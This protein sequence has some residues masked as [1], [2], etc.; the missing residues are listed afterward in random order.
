MPVVTG[1]GFLLEN[2]RFVTTRYVLEKW[3]FYESSKNQDEYK[4][5]EALNLMASNG[6]DVIAYFTAVSSTGKRFSFNSKSFICNRSFDKIESTELSRGVRM[7]V[8]KAVHG[9]SDWAYYQTNEK[10][11]LKY[12]ALSSNLPLGTELE[13][14][15]FSKG[16][17]PENSQLSPTHSK[18]NV[19]KV[20]ADPGSSIFNSNYNM[21]PGFAGGPVLIKSDGAYQVI[22]ILSDA[23]N[24]PGC[25]V[26]ISALF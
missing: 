2:G 26:P 19:A 22:G 8:R 21:E 16:R 17:Y 14:L 6:G 10:E 7:V 9:R 3:F 13:I 4:N 5:L 18:S 1:T 15:G 20:G 11:G 23:S 12:N 25:I 24:E